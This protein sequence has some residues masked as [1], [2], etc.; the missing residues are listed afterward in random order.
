MA[1]GSYRAALSSG[2]ENTPRSG[3]HHPPFREP[4]GV[5]DHHGLILASGAEVAFRLL[6]RCTACTRINTQPDQLHDDLDRAHTHR[7]G[8]QCERRPDGLVDCGTLPD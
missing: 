7:N 3:G 5:P 4:V 8:V 2:T 1:A 6:F